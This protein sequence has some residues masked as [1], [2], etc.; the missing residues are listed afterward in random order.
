MDD[1]TVSPKLPCP[2]FGSYQVADP[3][4]VSSLMQD[5][6]RLQHAFSWKGE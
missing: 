5:L 6:E 1:L 2:R 4:P 3:L